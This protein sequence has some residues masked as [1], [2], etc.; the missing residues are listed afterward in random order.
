MKFSVD[1]C[2]I[3]WYSIHCSRPTGLNIRGYSSAGRALDW[4]SRGQRFDPAYL[5]QKSS[6]F[7]SE[8][9]ENRNFF[10]CIFRHHFRCDEFVMNWNF[11]APHGFRFCRIQ[12]DGQNANSAFLISPKT[13]W[14]QGFRASQKI[15]ARKF[16]DLIN[17]LYSEIYKRVWNSELGNWRNRSI[18]FARKFTDLINCLCS[19]IYKPVWNAELGNWR[20]RLIAFTRKFAN[21]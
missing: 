20:N 1:K 7:Q 21:L 13:Q 9:I 3:L 19:E 15:F 17:C 2:T 14:F 10:V 11:F 6:G 18:A 16:T 12:G 4:Q 8:M 5:H